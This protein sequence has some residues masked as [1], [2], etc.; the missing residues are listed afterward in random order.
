MDP[1]SIL[2][3]IRTF[4]VCMLVFASGMIVKYYGHSMRDYVRYIW[5]RFR[6]LIVPTWLLIC[7][8][9][10]YPTYLTF[11][12]RAG[13][14]INDCIRSFT[15][16]GGMAYIWIVRVYFLLALISPIV[17][18]ISEY[19]ENSRVWILWFI[20]LFAVNALAVYLTDMIRNDFVKK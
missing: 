12:M 10:C 20:G 1:P 5:K 2:F 8:F 11:L 4:D 18:K 6:R 16:T 7:F 3:D 17:V 14:S 9:V 19:M 13:F 15:F